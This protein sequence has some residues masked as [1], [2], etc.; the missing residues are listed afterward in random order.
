MGGTCTALKLVAHPPRATQE[1][2]WP[3]F[4][5]LV[6]FKESQTKP[7]GQVRNTLPCED[8]TCSWELTSAHP[9][10][11]ECP[12]HAAEL[13]RLNN[14]TDPLLPYHLQ[15]QAAVRRESGWDRQSQRHIAWLAR[16]AQFAAQTPVHNAYV[17]VHRTFTQ[18][19]VERCGTSQ[20]S[21]PKQ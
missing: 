9:P 5:V 21:G 10:S 2:W 7:E 15:R 3:G 16:S 4:P 1:F 17:N 12:T 18:V 13:R 11:L 19:M 6:Y 14:A 20:N 8:A